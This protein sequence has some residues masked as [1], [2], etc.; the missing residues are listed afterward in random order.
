[1]RPEEAALSPEADLTEQSKTKRDANAIHRHSRTS[2]T[3]GNKRWEVGGRVVGEAFWWIY[4][5]TI[6]RD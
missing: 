6:R 1:M 3:A 5:A 2:T 4:A